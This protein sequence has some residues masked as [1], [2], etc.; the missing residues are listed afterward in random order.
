MDG[1]KNMKKFTIFLAATMLSSLPLV[2]LAQGTVSEQEV[3]SI[4]N[5]LRPTVPSNPPWST[6]QTPP[7]DDFRQAPPRSPNRLPQAPPRRSEPQF[8]SPRLEIPF[9]GETLF[10]DPSRAI[11]VEVY[12]EYD[13]AELTSEAQADLRALGEALTRDE[14]SRY[15]Y[16]IGGHTD[17]NGDAGYNQSLSE[18]RAMAVRDF[19][20]REYAV[21]PSRLIPWGFGEDRP[22]TPETPYASINR[23]VEVALIVTE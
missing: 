14:L 16:L 13:S 3:N 18:R 1:R 6:P 10:I 4:I 5:S 9:N 22:R 7:L 23:R 21:H 15:S 20:L 2:A 12:F 17:A 19:L 11:D 8:P